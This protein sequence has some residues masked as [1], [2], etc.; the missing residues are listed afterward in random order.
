LQVEQ[1]DAAKA[2]NLRRASRV[3]NASCM[4]TPPFLLGATLLFWGWQTGFLVFGTVMAVAIESA[5]FTKVRWEFSDDD[6]SRIWTFCALLFLVAAVYAFTANEGPADFRGLFQNPAFLAQRAGGASSARTAG[7]LIR[8]L[9][10]VFFV[11]VAAQAFSSREEISFATISLILRRRWKKAKKQD[12]P[13]P[14]GRSLNLSYPYFAVCLFAA[15]MHPGQD[16]TFFWGL[17]ALLTWALWS[18]HSRRFGIFIWAG[19]LAAAIALGYAGQHGIGQLQT[20]LDNY[21]PEWLWRLARRGFDPAKNRTALGQ[22]GRVKGSG[23]IVIWL[24]PKAGSRAPALL[25]EASYRYYGAQ[26]WYAGS[27]RD[28]T[29]DDFGN[30]SSE[31]NNTTWVLLPAKTNPA[32]VNLACYLE[33]R[34]NK[35][36][37]PTGLLPLPAGSGRLENLPAF[38]LAKNGM[39]AVLAEGPGLVVFDACY[40]PGAT[41]DSEAVTNL[42]L[43]LPER[44]IPALDQLFTELQL[45][46]P[47]TEQGL[48]ATLLAVNGF[49]Q[50]KF[51]YSTWQGPPPSAST[52]ETPLSRFLLSTHSGHCEY[53]ATATVLLLRRLGI[54]ARYAIGYAVHETSGSK[55]VVRQRDAHAWCLVWNN[56]RKTWED[57]DTTPA[58][59]VEEESKRASPWQLLSDLWSRVRFEFSKF[60]WGQTRVRKYILLALV[61][62]LALLLYQVIFRKRGQGHRRKS[63]EPEAAVAWPGLDSE[64][65]QLERKLTERGTARQPSEPLSE[66]LRRAAG[67]PGLAEVEHSLQELLRLHYRYRF[68]PHGLSQPDRDE[69]KRCA[70]ACMTNL[71]RTKRRETHGA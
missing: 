63:R 5:R 44:E 38:L 4:K 48:R 28:T 52:N 13:L 23:K 68:D 40:G 50:S 35:S 25:R 22:I 36:G 69:L 45:T 57:F 8:W 17:A 12:Q 65:Y 39:G 37:N 26:V 58:S 53:F 21:N 47:S 71:A 19:A 2:P 3:A 42:D 64:F 24:E 59:W 10:M 16:S 51:T 49:F 11:F 62:V 60:R 31:T 61:P 30:V 67:D 15:S 18:Q 29:R 27:S 33:S 20:Y 41:I 1:R 43:K 32:A 56:Y 54:P 6:F 70:T 9:P 66:W 7:A 55:Y 14:A 46:R 34:S